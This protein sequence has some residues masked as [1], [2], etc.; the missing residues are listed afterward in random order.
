MYK[1]TPHFL[2]SL[3][4][5]LHSI[6][7]SSGLELF[8]ISAFIRDSL[9][10]GVLYLTLCLRVTVDILTPICPIWGKLC[11]FHCRISQLLTTKE[12]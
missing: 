5:M 7:Q 2:D 4:L 1:K 6:A 9:P 11:L 10:A 8:K 12:F 3:V